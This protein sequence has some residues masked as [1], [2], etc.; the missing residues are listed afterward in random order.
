MKWERLSEGFVTRREPGTATALAAGSRCAL[1]DEGD[2]VCTYMVQSKLG[3]NDFVATLSRSADLGSTWTE[4][5]PI[6]PHLEDRSSD[7][8]SL[9]RAAAGDLFLYGIEMPIDWPGE[10]FWNEA[11]QGIKQ[12]CLG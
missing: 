3:I 10:T 1:T 11:T 4:Q 6:W 9:S 5:G 12:N 8:V 2:L 7:A